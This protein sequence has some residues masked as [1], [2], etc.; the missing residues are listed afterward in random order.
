[1]SIL[2]GN[3]QTGDKRTLIAVVLS[4]VV[5]SGGFLLQATLFPAPRAKPIQTAQ[6]QPTQT[7]QPTAVA[8][9]AQP[10][11]VAAQIVGEQ[12]KA[13]NL[14]I[15]SAGAKG[16]STQAAESPLS[17]RT[18]TISTD[19]LQA[20]LTNKGGD[21][22]SLK[23]KLHKDKEGAVDLVVPGKGGAGGLSLAFG[24]TGTAPVSDLMSAMQL[25]SSTI[26][27]SG[28]YL[29]MVPGKST[30][31]PFVM[32]KT[33]TFRNGEYMFGLA[34]SFENSV[35]EIIP[36]G[37]SGVCLL[38]LPGAADWASAHERSRQLHR[39]SPLCE[40]GRGQGK[41]GLAEGRGSLGREGP[42]DL[43]RTLGK[44]LFLPCRAGPQLLQDDLFDG[45]GPGAVPDRR[46]DDIS[47][48]HK[49]Q[50]ADGRVLFLFRAQDQYRIK[51]IQL[52]RQECIQAERPQSRASGQFL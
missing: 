28:K 14:S 36:L 5:I 40:A 11:P 35:N 34:V 44:V 50:Q 33:Y 32:K 21:L 13:S 52:R 24:D 6:A 25:D 48:G 8:E 18:Y 31:V 27:F 1:M 29:A 42:A 19:L 38:P 12:A 43:G 15:E 37:A 51:E 9:N 45:P 10:T 20:V 4:V 41:G 39:L 26:V 49:R 30:P 47:A 22:V 17:E 23:L 3:N 2:D 7:A 16:I 46:S